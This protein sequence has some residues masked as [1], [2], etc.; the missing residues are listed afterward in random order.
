M[1]ELP[2]VE[3]IKNDLKKIILNKNITNIFIYDEKIIK[4]PNLI[5]FKNKILNQKINNVLRIGKNLIFELNDLALIIHL[6]MEGK[7]L[8][9]N[10]NHLINIDDKNLKHN[11]ITLE[12][13]HNYLL[14]YLDS[15]KFGTMHLYS[16]NDYK[17][18]KQISKLGPDPF[19]NKLTINYLKNIWKNKNQSIKTCLLN[20][21]YI[22][23]IGNIYAD[24]ILFDSKIHPLTKS[25]Y[26]SDLDFSNLILNSKKIF[27]DAIKH[28][29]T[30]IKS[31]ETIN[32]TQ[33]NYQFYLKVHT[34]AN[35]LCKICKNKIQKIT[36][37]ARGTYLCPNCQ[38]YK[39]CL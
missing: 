33:S 13:E 2:E 14:Y 27:I 25:K 3:T 11:M 26:L 36:I 17:Y 4:F 37:N 9:K 30:K 35:F 5:E 39:N 12:L 28:K 8:F 21:Q 19:D 29:G 32:N 31:F 15:R 24:E 20:Q 23:G 7:F 6:R 1:P 10:K 34:R 16:I 22:S 18:S 38:I